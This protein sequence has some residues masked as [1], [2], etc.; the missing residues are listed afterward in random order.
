MTFGGHA[1]LGTGP[2]ARLRT[3]LDGLPPGAAPQET[4]NMTI[5]EPRH[6]PPAFVLRYLSQAASDGAGAYGRYPPI[7]GVESWRSAV[8]DWL[9]RRFGVTG[10]LAAEHQI[11]PVS[12]TREGLFLLA[13]MAHPDVAGKTHMAMPNPFY[14]VY[15]AAA[16]AAGATPL[17]LN[18]TAATGFL[19]DLDSLTDTE[20]ASLRAFFMCSPAN[21]QGAVATPAYLNRLLDLAASYDFLVIM[22]ECYADIYDR[23]LEEAP[24]TS[25]LQLAAARPEKA[26]NLVVFHSLSKRSNLPGLRSGFCA[27]GE[28]IMQAFYDFRLI[29]GPQTPIATLNAAALAWQDDDHAAANRALYQDKLDVAE[30]LLAGRYGFFR[31]QG[32]FFLWLNVGDGEMAAKRLWQEAGVRVLPGAYLSRDTQDGNPGQPYIR[33]ALVDTVEKTE[34]GLMKLCE[35]LA[36][37]GVR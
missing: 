9:S 26:E 27:G 17:Y 2:F 36:E 32:G 4:L 16:L 20:L 14:Q 11:L 25:A 12:G 8:T 34:T 31:P 19:P 29:A 7:G 33:L 28:N 3:L 37:D 10:L 30:S 24:P 18:A 23:A 22:D 21:P 35:V 1:D 13:Q 15:A 5:G 6:Q